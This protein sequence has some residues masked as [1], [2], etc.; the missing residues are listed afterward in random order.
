MM[1]HVT[2]IHLFP[3]PQRISVSINR[4]KNLSKLCWVGFRCL[5]VIFP[6]N[7]FKQYISQ[8]FIY[9]YSHKIVETCQNYKMSRR[10][11]TVYFSNKYFIYWQHCNHYKNLKFYNLLCTVDADFPRLV[12]LGIQCGAIIT[13][14]ILSK[15]LNNR[16]PKARHGVSLVILM[17]DS[18]SAIVITVSYM[19]SW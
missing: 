2:N 18:L 8:W 16:P 17:S 10:N 5:L 13:R 19:I 14:W 7:I 11:L 3:R 4:L 9:H 1:A 6:G 12:N 15:I